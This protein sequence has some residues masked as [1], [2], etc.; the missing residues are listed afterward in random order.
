MAMMSRESRS[1]DGAIQ[2]W[3]LCGPFWATKNTRCEAGVIVIRD[4]QARL[5]MLAISEI[6]RR[7]RNT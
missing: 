3:G 5:I 7:A 2:L 6:S 4:Y 1:N